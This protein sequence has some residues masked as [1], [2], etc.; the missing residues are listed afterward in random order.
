MRVVSTLRTFFISPE[1][2]LILLPFALMPYASFLDNIASMLVDKK[3]ELFVAAAYP[4]AVL[5]YALTQ[6]GSLIAPTGKRAV[7]LDWP[8]Y[9][10]LKSTIYIAV[11]LILTSLS[12]SLWGYVDFVLHG[13]RFGIIAIA[14]GGLS[15][16]V[17]A[18]TVLLA[19]WKSRELLGE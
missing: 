19:H 10:E 12:V 4:F 2:V 13:G 3:Y 11:A 16:S 9:G 6:A 18:F 5:L 7:L 8:G 17:G 1:M 15:S 14:A